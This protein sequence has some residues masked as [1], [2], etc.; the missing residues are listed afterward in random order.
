MINPNKLRSYG[1]MVW[2]NPFD[3]NRELRVETEVGE[4]IDLIANGKNIGFNSR[5]QT[6]HKLQSMLHVRLISNFQWNL[7]KFQIGEVRADAFKAKYM[8]CQYKYLGY[9]K[10]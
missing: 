9:T 8:A 2:N 10:A 4:T 3:S 7:E 5:T 1:T 6:E